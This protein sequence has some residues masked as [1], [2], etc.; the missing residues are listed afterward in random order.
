MIKYINEYID[1]LKYQ[2]NYSEHTLNNYERDIRTYI[3]YLDKNKINF[4]NIK[5]EQIQDFL[6]YL[7][8]KSYSKS[9]INRLLSAVRGYYKYLCSENIINVNPFKNISSLK[10]SKKLPNY[11]YTNEME[12]LLNIE[13]S[14]TPL[15]LRNELIIELLYDTGI[16]VSELVNIKLSDINYSSKTIKIL[17]KGNKERIVMF[18]D[19]AK[20][21][22]DKYMNESRNVLLSDK[23]SEYLLLNAKGTKLTDR[24]VR[25]IINL[26]S[27]KAKLN[28]HISP[29]TLRHTFAT[30]LLN[31]G[32]DL[33]TVKELLGHKNLSTTSIYT[34][35]SKEHLREVYLSSHP[36]GKK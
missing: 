10:R 3:D 26:Q 18:G 11:L 14:S 32:A 4:K 24:S 35:L 16:R 21:K 36:R 1:M 34:H 22:L 31:E 5:Y 12:D 23:Q 15:N 17:G 25:D 29:H 19:Y 33:T 7:H 2:R 27:T 9:T 6:E 20:E 28:H 13:E 30:H 8:D